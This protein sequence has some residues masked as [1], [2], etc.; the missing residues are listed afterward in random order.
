MALSKVE[1]DDYEVRGEYKHI[2]VRTK[3]SIMED[4]E[5]LSYKYHRRVLQPDADISAESDEL[6]ALAGALWT[7]DIK[8]AWADKQAEEV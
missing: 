5:E 4:G 7:D 6:K 8:K 2:N 3:T 1:K